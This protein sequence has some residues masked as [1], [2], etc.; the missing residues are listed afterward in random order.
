MSTAEASTSSIPINGVIISPQDLQTLVQQAVAGIAANRQG[1]ASTRDLRLAEPAMFVG[2]PEDLDDFLNDCELLFSI[3]EDV[4]DQ[5]DK[6][7]AYALSLMRNGNAGLWKKQYIQ[8]NFVRGNVLQDS[9]NRFKIKL[10]DAFKD[11]GR[12]EDSMKWLSH[13]KQGGRSI[14]E[15]N[16]LFRIH[17]T[18]AGFTFANNITTGPN[19]VTPN[20]SQGILKHLY[21]QAV[22]PKISSQIIIQGQPATI[23]EWMTKAAEM[24]SAFRR[25]NTLFA[26]GFQRDSGRKQA[27]KLRLVGSSRHH[28][29]GEP[30]D[31]DAF[32]QQRAPSKG[33]DWKKAAEC[34]NC[35]EKGHIARDCRKPKPQEGKA[36]V[37][38]GKGRQIQAP[39]KRFNPSQMRQH[40]RALIEENFEEGTDDYEAFVR[41]VED[42]GF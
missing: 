40:I 29:M 38:R 11:V 17:G 25:T 24:D 35:H 8:E 31:I 30:M 33:T 19:Q 6:K 21:Q 39:K 37:Q 36:V 22:N 2:R 5:D 34:Y 16:T 13:T 27:W 42:Q 14:E 7:I 9:W 1:E 23:N 20:P 28:D 3:K 41:E 12:A 32:T 10:R 18:R 4:Y 15:F 26:K